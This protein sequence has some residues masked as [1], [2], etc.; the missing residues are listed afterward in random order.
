MV[1]WRTSTTSKVARSGILVQ[2]GESKGEWGQTQDE[3]LTCA[4]CV[5]VLCLVCVRTEMRWVLVQLRHQARRW[6][7]EQLGES[8][9]MA[10]V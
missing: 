8:M 10:G 7:L 5:I 6:E 3:P 4:S 9:V 2:V 1:I